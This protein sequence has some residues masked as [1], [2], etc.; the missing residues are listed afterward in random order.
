MFFFVLFANPL[1][2]WVLSGSAAALKFWPL[3]VS[4]I[5][6]LINAHSAFNLVY[7]RSMCMLFT[8]QAVFVWL[9]EL[10]PSS[11]S[12]GAAAMVQRTG[13]VLA[14]R[15]ENFRETTTFTLLYTMYTTT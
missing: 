9:L 4:A 2:G 6:A 5:K 13:N 7:N 11:L 12:L 15:A 10:V 1:F 8:F 14:Q 3:A